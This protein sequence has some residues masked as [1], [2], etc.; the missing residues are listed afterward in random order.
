MAATAE[1]LQEIPCRPALLPGSLS[2]E[3]RFPEEDGAGSSEDPWTGEDTDRVAHRARAYIAARFASP[4]GCGTPE[5]AGQL[6]VSV[7]HLCHQYRAVH[8]R[9][10]TQE[11]RRLRVRAAKRL[12]ASTELLVKEVAA[13][14]GYLRS[15][16]RAFLN[17]FRAETGL[18]PSDYRL[19]ARRGGLNPEGRAF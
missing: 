13:E 12:L 18:R 17:A 11:V 7:S 9:T 8:G 14:V 16:Y 2:R 5:V 10:V 6:G 19:L 1:Q 15:S 3:A 4:D